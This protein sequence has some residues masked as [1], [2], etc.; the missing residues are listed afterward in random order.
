VIVKSGVCPADTSSVAAIHFFSTPFPNAVI[1]PDSVAI[2]YGKTTPLNATINIGTS[3]TWS[4]ASTLANQ[5]NGTVSSLPYTINAIAAPLTTTSYV[6]TVLNAGCPNAFLD[7][8]RVKAWPRIVV[9]AGNDTAI[10]NNQPLQLNAIVSDS[11]ANQFLW[12]PGT[13]LSSTSIRNPIATLNS[14]MVD[15]SI[16]YIVR[17]TNPTGCYGEDNITVRVFKTGPDIFVP[18]AFTPNGDSHNDVIRPILVG[19]KQLNYFR[20]YNRWGQLVFSTRESGKGWDG[21]IG[22]KEEPTGNFVF[23]VQGIDYTGRVI[24]KKGNVVLI[25]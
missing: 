15:E 25:R 14:S 21:R 11:A 17:A 6:L 22:G 24:S 16:T 8:F 13:G 1:N 23:V 12:S 2:C 7:T 19:I 18:T 9:F 3:Y 20:L 10:V 5:G 4:N